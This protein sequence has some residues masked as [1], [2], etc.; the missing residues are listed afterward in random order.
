[1]GKSPS[2]ISRCGVYSAFPAVRYRRLF[3]LVY[4]ISGAAA[5]IYEV[6]WTRLLTLQMGHGVAAASTVLA[7]FMGG[8]S[9]GSAV[10][11]HLGGRLS[12]AGALRAYA[13]IEIAIATLALALPLELAVVRPWLARAYTDGNPNV[14][15]PLLRLASS[16]FLLAAPAAAMGATFPIASRWMVRGASRAA[17]DAGW[18]YAVNTIGAALGAVLAGFVLLPALGLQ[19]TMLVGVGLNLTAATV[20]WLI[21]ARTGTATPRTSAANIAAPRATG[22]K[23]SPRTARVGLLWTAALALGLSGFASLTLQ[24][25]WTRLAALILGPTTYAFSLVVAVSIGGIAAGSALGSRLIARSHQPVLSLALCLLSSVGLATAAA[26]GVDRA[27]LL[28]AELVAVKDASFSSLLIRQVLL[29]A[30]LLAPMS[31]AFGAAFPFAIALGTKVDEKVVSDL[32]F[33]YAVNTSGAIIG[34][35]LA[36]FVL[37]PSLGL[38]DTIRVVTVIVVAGTVALLIVA[39]VRGRPLVVGIAACALVLFSGF[40]LPSWNQHLLSSGVYKHA[41]ELGSS[42][43]ET[44]LTAGR[45][46]YYREGATATV[47]VREALGNRSLSID[48]KVDASNRADMLTQRLLAHL[49]LLLHP[50]PHRVAIVGL[51]SGVTL[52]AALKH[53]IARADVLEISPEVVEASRFFEQE[54][55]RALADSRTR[56]IVG[57]GRLHLMLSQSPYDVIIS[58]P[59]NPWMAGVASLFTREFFESARRNL[60]P[61]GVLCQWAHTYDISDSDLRSIVATFLSVFPDGALWLIGKGDVLL[62]GSNEPLDARFGEMARQW[63][64]PGVATDLLDVGVRKPFDLLSMFVAE[65]RALARYA[66]GA[67][68]QTDDRSELEFSGPR[69]IFGNPTNLNDDVLRNLARAAPAPAAVQAAIRQA[70]P[71]DW[72]N[73]GWML[74]RAEVHELA[75]HDFGRALESDPTDTDAYKGLI[76]SSIPGGTPGM[77]EALTLLRRLAAHPSH[78]QAKVALS[79]L[80]AASG[81][82][83]EA[84]AQI[85]DLSQRYPDNLEVLEQWASVMADTGNTEHLQSVVARLR[86]TAPSSQITHYYSASLLFLQGRPD[87]AVPEAESVVRDNPDHA[88]AQ[89]LLGAALASLGQPVRARHAFEASL[90][91]NPLMPGTY[92]NLAMLEMETGHP[93]VAARRYAEALLLNPM[94]EPARRGLEEAAARASSP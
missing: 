64:R 78:L 38:H 60:A 41:A 11:G 43:L 54:N 21:A 46:L 16:L 5:L 80:L 76:Q 88:L 85:L 36:G 42:N 57:D 67:A 3:L 20:T 19:R 71:A 75:W 73:R 77:D 4:G 40:A 53:P 72:R 15:F 81:A 58:E 26:T 14:T 13:I 8:L 56:L 6:T 25:V 12:P 9:I 22:A 1:M 84:A 30:A 87:L 66:D 34:A 31:I 10:G 49:P 59:S 24:V 51:G 69:S 35:L 17:A 29:V 91:A 50:E 86:R 48:G 94:S 33:I 63:Q 2:G 90:R 7:A 37:I 28:M 18:L 65:G 39:R 45:L 83:D 74:I 92:V 44:W 32:G 23:P 61:G 52:G 62:V 93:D 79:H 82:T 89:N 68:V 27:L 47:S 70:G 55:D